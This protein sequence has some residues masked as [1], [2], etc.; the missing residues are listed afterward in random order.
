MSSSEKK[1]KHRVQTIIDFVK[2]KELQQGFGVE[3]GVY[4]GKVSLGLMK[5]FPN[6]CLVSVDQWKPVHGVGDK[7]TTGHTDYVSKGIEQKG[8]AFMVNA[9]QYRGRLT[10][11]K[12]DSLSASECYGDKKFDFIF[13]DADHRRS[14]I[15]SDI[16]VWM[17]KLVDGGYLLGHDIN[18]KEVRETID[19]MIPG[20]KDLGGN[21]W[22][23]E[24]RDIITLTPEQK[25]KLTEEK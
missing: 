12:T 18:R 9:M 2:E 23:V 22:A 15:R 14:Y 3:V 20:W 19:V 17:P 11:L 8:V 10:V 21:V 4:E 1:P 16:A 24:K 25:R 7:S 13:I 6:L 5:T